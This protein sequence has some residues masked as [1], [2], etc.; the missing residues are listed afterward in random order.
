MMEEILLWVSVFLQTFLNPALVTDSRIVQPSLPPATSIY[1]GHLQQPEETPLPL[2]SKKP[3]KKTAV[4][5]VSSSVTVSGVL[6]ALNHYRSQHG[7]GSLVIDQKLQDYAQSRANYLK[8]L[9]ELDKHE[10]HQEFMRGDGF[11]KLGFNAVAENQSWNFK[12][13]NQGLIS[14]F[15]GKSPGHNSNQ[16]NSEYTH[17]GIGISGPFT[18]IV[19]GGRRK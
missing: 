1:I 18:N 19:F 6:Q 9:G 4:K 10:G 12:G 8:S 7:A 17:A 3:G 16:L 11:G 13:S 5:G 14:E 2:P 15:Y